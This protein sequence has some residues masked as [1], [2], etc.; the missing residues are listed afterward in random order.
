MEK[1]CISSMLRGER[2]AAELGD[3]L[4]Y[5]GCIAVHLSEDRPNRRGW[6]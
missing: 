4:L 5:G 2:D 3:G 6:G 1:T